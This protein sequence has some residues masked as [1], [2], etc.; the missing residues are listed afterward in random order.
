MIRRYEK[1]KNSGIEWIGEI[2]EDWDVKKLKY[3]SEINPTKDRTIS[4]NSEELVT[5]LPMEKVGEKGEINCDIRKP[6]SEV[7]SGFTF[8]KKN[9]V[10]LAK[11]T[12]CFE[13]GKGALLKSMET[14]IGFGSTEFH[15]LRAKKMLCPGFLYFV[16]KSEIFMKTGE[17][18]MTGAAGQKRVPTDF[19]SEF[20]I[21]F[22]NVI[23]QSAIAAF[24]DLKTSELDKLIAYKEKLVYLYEEEKIAI[25]NQIITKG[26]DSGVKL[27]PSGVDWLED[28]PE[29]WEVKRL[30]Y[31]VSK[32]GSGV[33]PKGG[34][35][36]YQLDGIP[37]LRSQNIH[38]DGL[39][40]DDVAYIS[41]ETHDEMSNSKVLKGDV[42]LNI[43][44]ASIGR[45]YFVE[46]SLGEA[47]VNQHVCIIR[48]KPEVNT[49]YLFY[50]MYSY[51]GQKQIE[52]EQTGSGRE[53][54]NFECL[55]N[56]ILLVPPYHE[57]I[58]IIDKIEI[59]IK[60]LN[61]IIQKLIKQIELYQEYRKTLIS[62]VVTGKIDVRGE[63][64]I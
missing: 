19:I 14:E 16:T 36:V 8:F 38:F 59:K 50:L 37:L 34:A 15:V 30:K 33:T 32:V 3:V 25:I 2:P 35:S 5:F 12:P 46:N 42:L 9:D 27:K 1:Y 63:V 45:C 22:P 64:A 49:K 18:F 51:V 26:L 29:H 40:L 21:A 7:W 17:A 23:E 57:Q 4:P 20:V 48:P 55:K 24:L 44:G 39:R 54:L 43:T 62:E 58:I 31:F 47:N 41:Q 60:Q 10:I 53:G 52:I 28:I 11:I 61:T 6:I 13:N 56:F